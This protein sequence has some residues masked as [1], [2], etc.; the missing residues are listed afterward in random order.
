VKERGVRVLSTMRIGER[1]ESVLAAGR[2]ACPDCGEP[3]APLGWA[4]ER[5]VRMRYGGRLVRARRAYC[6]RCART[7]VLLPACCVPRR[8]DGAEV[9]GSALLAKAQGVG[10]RTI[11]ARLDRP[12][13]TVRG[14]LRA[15]ARRTGTLHGVGVTW[16]VELGDGPWM[17]RP[18]GRPFAVA[19]QALACAARA[20]VL[21]F[22]RIASV[23]E[24][25]VA[26]CGGE[27]LSHGVGE[28]ISGDIPQPLRVSGLAVPP[29]EPADCAAAVR[30]EAQSRP[31]KLI[32]AF[33]EPEIFERAATLA[34][35]TSTSR[36]RRCCSIDSHD[37]GQEAV[38]RGAMCETW[39][40][41]G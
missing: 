27:L 16:T 6:R 38:R 13:G 18:S 26:V 15:F 5:E 34:R 31:P 32:Q 4:R 41:R 11:A 30:H 20:Y 2:V 14:W 39:D 21:R 36:N 1:L 3:L 40:D 10:H 28:P 23:W 24:L 17:P 25:I 9:I 12:P 37:S 33:L 7:H 35:S 22:G 19:L 29:S 8:R